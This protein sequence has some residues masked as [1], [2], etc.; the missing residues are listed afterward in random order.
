MAVIADSKALYNGRPCTDAYASSA[1]GAVMQATNA[2]PKRHL[3]GAYYGYH[4]YHEASAASA[5]ASASGG[6]AS[7]AAA[8]A[9]SGEWAVLVMQCEMCVCPS[10]S[11]LL[12]L[13]LSIM[14][15]VVS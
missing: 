13:L 3:L 8:A 4:N 7:G 9:T 12:H 14:C 15:S 5:A 11:Q 10:G 2:G 6:D 1:D